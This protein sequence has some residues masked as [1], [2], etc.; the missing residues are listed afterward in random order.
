VAF[1]FLFGFNTIFG[2]S[3]TAQK[4]MAFAGQAPTIIVLKEGV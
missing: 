1:C 2:N 3:L 4:N